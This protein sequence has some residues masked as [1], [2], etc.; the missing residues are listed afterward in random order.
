[1]FKDNLMQIKT[2]HITWQKK[3]YSAK[4]H[5]INLITSIQLKI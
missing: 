2:N 5:P 3:S 1:M 4:K